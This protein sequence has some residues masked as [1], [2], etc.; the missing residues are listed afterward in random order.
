MSLVGN[1]LLFTG[2]VAGL[3]MIPFGLPG[4]GVIFGS[5]LLYA[6]LTQF[7]S[8]ISVNLILILAA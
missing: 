5:A 6:L 8:G 1:L 7:N 4:I 3:A 2:M